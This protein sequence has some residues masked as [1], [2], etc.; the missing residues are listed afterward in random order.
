MRDHLRLQ[1]HELSLQPLPPLLKLQILLL[2][3]PTSSLNDSTEIPVLLKPLRKARRLWWHHGGTRSSNWHELRLYRKRWG[4]HLAA[5]AARSSKSLWCCYYSRLAALGGAVR[6]VQF[7]QLFVDL[8][9]RLP[10][11]M[12][13]VLHGNE[14]DVNLPQDV[15]P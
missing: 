1:T 2:L 10:S 7:A 8:G 12:K 11:A 13:R 4:S 3:I 14:V 15:A 5:T 6:Q 9:E